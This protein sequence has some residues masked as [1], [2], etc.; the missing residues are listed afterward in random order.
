[1]VVGGTIPPRDVDALGA[2][3]AAA[4]FPMGTPLREIVAAVKACS[5]S[6]RTS[7]GWGPAV[8]GELGTGEVKS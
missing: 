1:V 4:V 8:R 5:A 3:G 2:L 6:R 7:R